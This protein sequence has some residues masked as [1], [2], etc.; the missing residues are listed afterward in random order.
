[1]DLARSEVNADARLFVVQHKS[2]TGPLPHP[3]TQHNH[4]VVGDRVGERAGAVNHHA[5]LFPTAPIS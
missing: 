2:G 4:T 3:A 1:M 5:R